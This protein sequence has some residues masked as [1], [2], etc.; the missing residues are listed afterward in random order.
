[1]MRWIVMLVIAAALFAMF[2]FADS[3]WRGAQGAD[4]PAPSATADVAR[5]IFAAGVLTGEFEEI[6]LRFELPGRVLRVLADVGM[7][8]KTGQVLAELESD[9]RDLQFQEAKAQ[10]ELARAERELV[11]TG[12]RS[13]VA[14]PRAAATPVT[15]TA[16]ELQAADARVRIAEAAV[17]Y[18]RLLLSHTRLLAP[19]DGEIVFR[20][21]SPGDVVNPADMLDHLVLAPEGRSVVKAFVEELD[22]LDVQAGQQAAISVP[23]YRDRRLHG[24]I[25]D[26]APEL[27]P[28][29]QR[30]NLPGERLD[31]RV[32]EVTI[33]LDEASTLPR[34]LPVEVFISPSPARGN[35]SAPAP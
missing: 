7:H 18:Q 31:V 20:E 32:R 24:V 8:V 9:E 27:R 28:K 17:N 12:Q 34:G 1:M 15:A 11:R 26:C 25:T 2:Y 30:H 10:L 3:W 23:A 19:C 13:P 21:L 16:E 4:A 5:Q 22:A 35:L 33:L 14:P 6:T 29:T